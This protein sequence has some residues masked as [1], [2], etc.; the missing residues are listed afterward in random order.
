MRTAP[1]RRARQRPRRPERPARRCGVPAGTASGRHVR[2]G[3]GQ[4]DLERPGSGPNVVYDGGAA[5]LFGED[6]WKWLVAPAV[7]VISLTQ[8]NDRVDD[9]GVRRAR[10]RRADGRCSVVRRW[11]SLLVA[12]A[13][14]PRRPAARR[15]TAGRPTELR[16]SGRGGRR[17]AVLLRMDSV[18][19]TDLTATSSG[20][21]ELLT[22]KQ[23]A[24][25][26]SQFAE[27]EKRSAPTRSLKAERHGILASGVA[28]IDDDCATVLVAHDGS[29]KA[30]SGTTER[31]YRWTSTWCKVDGDV[32]RR[33]LQPGELSDAMTCH[34]EPDLVRRPRRRPATRPP[35]RSRPPGAPPPTSSSPAPAPASSG[36]STRR[37]TCCSTPRAPSGVRRRA[38][39]RAASARTRR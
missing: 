9:P 4:G 31:H 8:G 7:D 6:S 3:H 11:P 37:P 16:P 13:S 32:A 1:S 29:V 5:Q 30:T 39:R 35:T 10:A 21:A 26:T 34:P 17:R 14:H 38:R 20:S 33:R 25:F 15:R 28:D 36:C 23:K 18:D 12:G 19:G 27:F 2:S 24:K 22:T